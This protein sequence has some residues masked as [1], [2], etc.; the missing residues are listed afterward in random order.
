MEGKGDFGDKKQIGKG[1]NCGEIPRIW[2]N[3]KAK[4]AEFGGKIRRNGEGGEGILWD[5]Q[6]ERK[7]DQKCGKYAN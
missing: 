1:K 5:D 2:R 3:K 4:S 6:S 7:F